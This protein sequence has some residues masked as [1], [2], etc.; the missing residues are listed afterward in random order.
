[1]PAKQ[2]AAAR[3]SGAPVKTDV[4]PTKSR[5]A[6][7]LSFRKN[8]CR[9]TGYFGDMDYFARRSGVCKQD[10]RSRCHLRNVIPLSKTATQMRG[11]I[12]DL[13]GSSTSKAVVYQ[14]CL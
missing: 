1:M 14:F 3:G 7:R 11:S 12:S 4:K 6:Y 2:P 5:K 9:L 10:A 8:K 13:W